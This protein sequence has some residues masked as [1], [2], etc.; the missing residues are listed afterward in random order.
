MPSGDATSHNHIDLLSEQGLDRWCNHTG[1]DNEHSRVTS[2]VVGGTF[3]YFLLGSDSRFPAVVALEANIFTV[4]SLPGVRRLYLILSL[5]GNL[6]HIRGK[7]TPSRAHQDA[8]RDYQERTREEDEDKIARRP[9][10]WIWQ[11]RSCDT[12]ELVHV[13]A[14]GEGQRLQAT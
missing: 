4:D 3:L 9:K 2:I 7:K 11:S 12:L 14:I 1:D 6:K 13:K 5:P 8:L 10:F